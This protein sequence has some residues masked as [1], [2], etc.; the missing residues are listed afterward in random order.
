LYIDYYYIYRKLSQNSKIH[1]L[2]INDMSFLTSKFIRV[3][4]AGILYGAIAGFIASWS[5]STAIAIAE[6]VL[7]LRIS[8]FYSILGL[9]S[10]LTDNFANAAYLGFGLHILTGAILGAVVGY[11][12]TRWKE[13]IMLKHYKGTLIGMAAGIIIWLVLFLPI[14]A[15]L[16]QPSINHIVTVLALDSQRLISSDNINQAIRN[17]ALSAIAFHLIWGAI[18]GYIMTS[19]LRIRAFK[20]DHNKLDSELK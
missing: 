20:I 7:G 12:I 16:I 8:T 1:H 14:T 17:I 4:Y 10:G 15:L 3:P 9:S 2:R 5:I 19:L 11:I 13:S 6:V 18:F